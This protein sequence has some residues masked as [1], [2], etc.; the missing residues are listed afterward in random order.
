MAGPGGHNT[1]AIDIVVP[2]P[3][4]KLSQNWTIDIMTTWAIDIVHILLGQGVT[5]SMPLILWPHVPIWNLAKN[6]TIDI[7]ATWS[8]DIVTGGR[9]H[10]VNIDITA[11]LAMILCTCWYCGTLPCQYCAFY[12]SGDIANLRVSFFLDQSLYSSFEMS[13]ISQEWREERV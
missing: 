10:N 13:C 3:N 12:T 1:N 5:I 4:Q 11:S 9:G 2:C 7:M 6:W 8:I